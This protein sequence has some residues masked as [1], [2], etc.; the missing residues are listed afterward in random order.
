MATR[1][2]PIAS[3][4]RSASP[5]SPASWSRACRS[6][7]ASPP[8]DA[9]EAAGAASRAT[10]IVGALGL[11]LLIAFAAPL[12]ALLPEP[13]LAAVVIAAL[14]HALDPAPLVR[15]WQL[16]RDQ[17]VALGAAAGVLLL[18]VLDGMLVAIALSLAALI[19][20][21]ASPHVARLGRLGGGHD[22]VDLARHPEAVS[23]PGIAIWRPAEPLFFANAE[24]ILAFI[25]PSTRADPDDPR[26]R[27]QP[28]GELR[29]RQHRARS[30]D[31]SRYR[32]LRAAG[33]KRRSSPAR[34]IMSAI[35]W[36]RRAARDLAARGSL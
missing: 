25:A 14:V 34:T 33:I 22:F 13:V 23:P 24:R 4:A 9:S 35:C 18:G 21:L 12:I 3:S 31:R 11:G 28:R 20:R 5:I 36:R 32:A 17:Y 19:R 27:A 8:G 30:A 26:D 2:R 16:D 10:A 29:S 6:A 7:P 15:L 1:S